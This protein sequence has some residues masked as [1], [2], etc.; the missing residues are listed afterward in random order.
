MRPLHWT[1]TVM[2][3][4]IIWILMQTMMEYR[5][6][7]K[8]QQI[9]MMTA[10]QTIWTVI[11]MVTKFRIWSRVLSILMPMACRIILTATLMATLFLTSLKAL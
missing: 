9:P 11:Q 2:R 3:F 5:M 1:Q 10:Y 6:Q 4:R 8:A 7:L